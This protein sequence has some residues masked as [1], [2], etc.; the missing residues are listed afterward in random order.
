MPRYLIEREFSEP[1]DL[2]LRDAVIEG[3]V[4][5]NSE[6]GV[7]WIESFV[8]PDRKRSF[9]IYDAPTPEAVRRTAKQNALP[10]MR[11]WEVTLLNPY[12]YA[13]RAEEN[14]SA[15]LPDDNR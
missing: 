11:I 12:S 3:V 8:T 13:Y 14:P 9:C 7:T 2:S 10:V 6:N 15:R 5:T 1:L 4:A